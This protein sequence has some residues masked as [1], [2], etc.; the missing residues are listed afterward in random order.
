MVAGDDEHVRLF[1]QQNRQRGVEIFDRLHLR[2]EIAVLAGFVRVFVMDEKEIEV[3]VFLQVTLELFWMVCASIF[4]M[5]T[6]CARPLY[7]G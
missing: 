7:I 6:S 3:V 4:F 2:D 1:P 5:P